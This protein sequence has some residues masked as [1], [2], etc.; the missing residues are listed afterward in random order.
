VAGWRPSA[1]ALGVRRTSCQENEL[2]HVTW[3]R[4]RSRAPWHMEQHRVRAMVG[5]A[6]TVAR[7]SVDTTSHGT[8]SALAQTV[9]DSLKDSSC[10]QLTERDSAL[11][12]VMASTWSPHGELPRLLRLLPFLREVYSALIICMPVE[13]KATIASALRA[14]HDVR[15]LVDSD[16]SNGVY[17]AVTESLAIDYDYLHYTDMD[18][19]LRWAETNPAEFRDTAC[20]IAQADCT[21]IGRTERA[22]A[23]HPRCMQQTEGLVNLVTSH[24]LGF[25]ADVCAGSRGF[26]RRAVEYLRQHSRPGH[27][28]DAEWP[29]LLLRAGFTIGY[30]KVDGL[31][32]ETADRYLPQA[33]DTE[34]QRQA[35]AAYDEQVANWAARVRVAREIIENCLSVS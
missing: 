27:L 34:T 33:A 18:R 1:R 22:V 26:S 28:K 10:E 20:A 31:D 25:K 35:A 11:T 32:W 5:S 12:I 9:A 6:D 7:A 2:S 23:T 14:E 29:L 15:L 19:L 16:W 30:V 13:A 3:P 4:G 8:T 21:I 17:A 24:Q